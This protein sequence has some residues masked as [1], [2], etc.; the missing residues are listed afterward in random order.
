MSSWKK[1]PSN[2][3]SS[4]SHIRGISHTTSSHSALVED[5]S[6]IPK[7]ATSCE[8]APRP[9]PISN[10]PPESWS[11]MAARSALRTGW[12]TRGLRL[13]MPDPRWMRS[14]AWAR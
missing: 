9:V 7:V 3:Y 2:V 12:L 11:S 5:V 6:W 14:V 4:V 8:P 10:R 1:V 13:K